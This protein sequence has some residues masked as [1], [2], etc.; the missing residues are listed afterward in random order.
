MK[1][2]LLFLMLSTSAIAQPVFLNIPA[3][4]NGSPAMTIPTASQQTCEQ[5]M[6]KLAKEDKQNFYLSCSIVPLEN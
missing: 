6:V 4:H 1:T 5:L 2:L 3:E